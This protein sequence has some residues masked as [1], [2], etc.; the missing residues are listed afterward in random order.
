MLTRKPGNRDR[1][2]ALEVARELLALPFVHQRMRKQPRC[3]SRHLLRGER[4]HL[5]KRFHARWKVG[6][7]EQVGPT[8]ALHRREQL[9]HMRACLFFTYVRH[10]DSCGT[11]IVL[12]GGPADICDDAYERVASAVAMQES[13]HDPG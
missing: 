8:G 10:G 12:S 3:L 13:G 6:G 4:P 2:I 7:D 1:E 5:S 9:V 11:Q